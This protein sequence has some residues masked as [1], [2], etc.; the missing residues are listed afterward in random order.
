[1]ETID[2]VV[3]VL[4]NGTYSPA[5][6]AAW[7]SSDT[8]TIIGLLESRPDLF[9]VEGF[10]WKLVAPSYLHLFEKYEQRKETPPSLEELE[11]NEENL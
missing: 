9:R 2:D 5:Y 7:L 6:I 8:E 10:E 3:A 4:S 1:M 11:S